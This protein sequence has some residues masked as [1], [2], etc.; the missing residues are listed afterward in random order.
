MPVETIEEAKSY[1]QKG[2]VVAGERNGEVLEG[3]ELGNSPFSFM[4]D[5]LKGKNIAL[6]T[7]NGTK[8]IKSAYQAESIIIGAFVNLNSVTEYLLRLKKNVLVLCAGWKDKFNLEDTLFAGAV[9]KELLNSLVFVTSCDS[10]RAAILLYDRAKDDLENFAEQY[11][12]FDYS[13]YQGCYVKVVVLCKQNP[14]LFDIVIDSLYKAGVA[15]ISIVEDFGDI[16]TINDDVID[17]AEDTMTILSKYIDNLTLDVESAK[18]KNIMHELYIE[19][20][21]TETE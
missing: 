5:K 16:E 12:T 10:T 3:F 1:S 20:L 2:F 4:E 13:I 15:D 18:L 21:S 19:A 17:E 7:T 6:T 9:A 8:A 11:K 14:F